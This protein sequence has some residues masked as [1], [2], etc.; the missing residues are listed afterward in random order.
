MTKADKRPIAIIAGNGLLPLEAAELLTR[1]GEPIYLIGIAGEASADITQYD[2]MIMEWGQIGK[3]FKA[4]KAVDARSIL[5]AG[6]IVR[7]P[8]IDLR[9]LDWGAVRTLPEILGVILSGDNTILS[10]VIDIFEKRG[11]SVA[12]MASRTSG[13]NIVSL[14][15]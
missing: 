3:L 14:S 7:R 10:G 5:L 6:G 4:L 12:S 15:P 9:K 2:H 13:R 11:F 8:D 1:K